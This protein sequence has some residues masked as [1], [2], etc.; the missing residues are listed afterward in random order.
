VAVTAGPYTDTLECCDPDAYGQGH[1]SFRMTH[2]CGAWAGSG[3]CTG[4]AS[5]L[6]LAVT[7]DANCDT[8]VSSS[9]MAAPIT[10][11]GV[12]PAGMAGT[13]ET[14]EGDILDWEIS[15]AAVVENPLVKERC[16][17]CTCTTVLPRRLCVTVAADGDAYNPA[18]SEAVSYL[19]N[20]DTKAWEADGV[21]PDGFSL[22]LNL[23][24]AASQVCG[25][26]VV[27]GGDYGS[28]TGVIL[29]ESALHSRKFH[30]TI[31]RDSDLLEST[32][33][34]PELY[35]CDPPTPCEDPPPQDWVSYI[36]ETISLLDDD[37]VTVT[38]TVTIRDQACGE[39]LPPC[40]L[41]T[42]D[43]NPCCTS[44]PTLITLTQTST[45]DTAT[46]QNLN[47]G[48]G[49][50]TWGQIS[51]TITGQTTPWTIGCVDGAWA[52]GRFLDGPDIALTLDS[53]NPFQLS[54]G[55]GEWT[56]TA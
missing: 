49:S 27:A 50:R 8:V 18:L 48:T 3:I 15:T 11:P 54:E 14:P 24:D 25:I 19:W 52:I 43:P 40:V 16:S 41:P 56:V 32:L 45:G 20:C 17:P 33:G 2:T 4:L 26:D 34:V 44:P 13:A 42:P 22:S 1:F 36:D 31:C 53:C 12:L 21:V 5:T 28:Y 46:F 23:K 51:G 9:M 10:F 47:V 30:G 37:G 39:C 38:G 29:L 6:D 55:T 35:P 7:L